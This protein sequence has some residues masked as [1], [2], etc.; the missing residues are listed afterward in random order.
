[1]SPI[2]W[3]LPPSDVFISRSE[4]W[5]DPCLAQVCRSLG[6]PETAEPAIL[7]LSEQLDAA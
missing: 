6:Y 3:A 1:M 7:L 2:S 5:G 4:R